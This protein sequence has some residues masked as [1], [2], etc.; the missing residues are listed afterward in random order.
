[1]AWMAAAMLLG[2][3]CVAQAGVVVTVPDPNTAIADITLTDTHANVFSA[4][5]TLHFDQA[6]DLSPD[7]LGLSAALFDPATPP[8]T[9]PLNVAVD[10]NFPVVITVEPPTL[11]F[12]N[13]YDPGQTSDGNLAFFDTYELE[14]HTPDL[15]CASASTA[16]RLFKAPHGSN[17]F[18]DVTDD[19]FQGSV[20]ARGRG[21]SFSRFIVV[22][23]TNDPHALAVQKL[24]DL[25]ARL[26]LATVSDPALLTVLNATLANISF[27]LLTS[28]IGGALGQLQVFINDVTMAAGVSIANEWKSDRSVV[29]DAGELISLAQTLQFTL[30]LLQGDALCLSPP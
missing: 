18:A 20:R 19:V 10:P 16:Y 27:D 11:L 26:A 7:S 5:V 21:G 2:A 24:A 12:A 15:A 22:Q 8:G 9:L 28:N 30:R 4:T 17:A 14:V 6:V 29:N 25:T 23:D 1:M 3:Q 13:G